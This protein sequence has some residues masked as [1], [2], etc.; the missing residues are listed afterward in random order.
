MEIFKRNNETIS[1]KLQDE[2]VLLDIDKG[3]YFSL[4]PIA[5]RIWEILSDPKDLEEL[6]VELTAIYDVP[7]EQCKKETQQYLDEMIKLGMIIK[8]H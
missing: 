2:Q 5:T 6:C 3:K 8:Q 1:G 4:N 7:L